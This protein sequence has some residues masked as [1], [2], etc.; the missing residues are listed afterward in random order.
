[1]SSTEAGDDGT[2]TRATTQAVP[3]LA[4]AFLST[5][6][7]PVTPVDHDVHDA[8]DQHDLDDQYDH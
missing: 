6:V 1:M 4:G 7:D 8:A 3:A 5:L 2:R